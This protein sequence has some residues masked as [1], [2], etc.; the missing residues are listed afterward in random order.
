M[1]NEL[2]SEVED[3]ITEIGTSCSAVAVEPD[4]D[5]HRVT[6]E[7]GHW[8][9]FESGSSVGIAD[10]APYRTTYLVS[11]DGIEQVGERRWVY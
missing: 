10:G 1:H 4:V 11:A 3:T 8:Y 7:C 2:L 9:E 5:A 6:V